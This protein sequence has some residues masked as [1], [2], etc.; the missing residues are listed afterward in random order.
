MQEQV[1]EKSI[2]LAIKGSKLTGR[3]L[4]QAM[5]AALRKLKEPPK[6]KS[7]K[8]SIRSLTKDGASLSNAELLD[9]NARQFD[10][11]AR[12]YNVRY[13]LKVDRSVTPPKWMVFF[14]AKDADALTAAFGEYSKVMLK[15]KTKKPTLLARLAKFKEIIK[16]FA[17]PAKNR[18]KGGHER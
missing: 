6:E 12:K 18:S 4:A 17:T 11:I 14:K 15:Q 2:A 8:Q 7:G 9:P 5:K 1:N 13:H 3:L 10:R 16:Q